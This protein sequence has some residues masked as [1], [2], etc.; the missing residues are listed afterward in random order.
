MDRTENAQ[1]IIDEFNQNRRRAV[2]LAGRFV[3]DPDA[4][5]DAAIRCGPGVMKLPVLAAITI[6]R[7]AAVQ[8]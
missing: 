3:A 6:C 5:A 7:D 2:D 8:D 1:R 4:V